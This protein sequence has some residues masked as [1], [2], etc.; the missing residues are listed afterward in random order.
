MK[1]AEFM[2]LLNLYLDHEISAADAA[3]LEIEVQ[4][5]PERRRVY[6]QYCQMQKAC[7]ML[8]ADF[9]TE[10]VT[11]ADS[12][13]KRVV[14][15]ESA[16][17]KGRRS[18]SIYAIGAVAAAAACVAFILSN[19]RLSED[20]NGAS[21]SQERV[22]ISPPA[23]SNASPLISSAEPDRQHSRTAVSGL[24]QRPMLVNDPLLL[25][26]T[27]NMATGFVSSTAPV[28]DELAWIRTLR[29]A[30]LP[31]RVSVEDLR[32][33]AQPTGLH[34]EARALGINQGPIET[35]SEMAAFRFTK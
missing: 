14:P 2:E 26:G 4:S 31:S 24:V 11:L 33:D 19:G 10:P 6:Q 21:T 9:R 23:T 29:L 15:F 22:A 7:T 8:V 20:L 1:N 17:V 13:G 30:P 28:N 3:R 34:P 12:R 27:S 18:G 35:P 25:G 16:S 32:F 5:D